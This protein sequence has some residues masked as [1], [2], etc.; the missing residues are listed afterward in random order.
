[1]HAPSIKLEVIV[2]TATNHEVIGQIVYDTEYVAEDTMLDQGERIGAQGTEAASFSLRP[3]LSNLF[4]TVL[5]YL[6]LNNAVAAPVA[7]L[8]P[9]QV[10]PGA[11]SMIDTSVQ[12]TSSVV[13]QVLHVSTEGSIFAEM[14]PLAEEAQPRISWFGA[15]TLYIPST[16][17]ELDIDALAAKMSD[18]HKNYPDFLE[19][20]RPLVRKISELINQLYD[21]NDAQVAACN[22]ITRLITW[23]RDLWNAMWPDTDVSATR[24]FWRECRRINCLGHVDIPDLYTKSQCQEVFGFDPSFGKPHEGNSVGWHKRWSRYAISYYQRTAAAE[25]FKKRFCRVTS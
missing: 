19:S 8:S 14:L 25:A 20:E 17:E 1:M 23:I 15:R 7:A 5:A 21:Q 2:V 9:E 13:E 16:G 22:C 12:A 10:R 4:S 24:W 11:D 3:M 6:G 18:L